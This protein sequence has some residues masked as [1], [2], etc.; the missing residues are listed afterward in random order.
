MDSL[1]KKEFGFSSCKI[2]KIDGYDNA[3]Y[4]VNH[5][6]ID[7]V[8]KTY[9]YN[10]ELLAVLIAENETLIY[11]N[12]EEN[13]FP[14]PIPFLSGDLIKVIPI[15]GKPTICRMLSFFRWRVYW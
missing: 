9:N 7:Y 15:N 10:K 14:K 2:K 13:K 12:N 8:F 6:S 3:N 5:N 1:L 11:L 4:I